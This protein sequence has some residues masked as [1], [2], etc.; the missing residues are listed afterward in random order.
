[1]K[2][3]VFSLM[4]LLFSFSVHAAPAIN[5]IPNQASY[6]VGDIVLLAVTLSE[7]P[8][9]HGGG[10]NIR[11]NPK[12]LQS[13][14]VVVDKVWS[15]ASKP[16]VINNAGGSITD[17]LFSSFNPVGGSQGVAVIQLAVVG[18]GDSGFFVTVS[19]KN[20]FVDTNSQ[21]VSFSVNN[22]FALNTQVAE[23]PVEETPEQVTDTPTEADEDVV[24]VAEQTTVPSTS[25]DVS[26]PVSSSNAAL[27]I[28]PNDTGST[29]NAVS[30][31]EIAAN[32]QN[33]RQFYL[34]S[35]SDRGIPVNVTDDDKIDTQSNTVVATD[36]SARPNGTTA[37]SD[38]K[39]FGEISVDGSRL[40][41]ATTASGDGQSD[42]TVTELQQSDDAGSMEA[43]G[44]MDSLILRL[45][46]GVVFL[47][48]VVFTIVF[49][50]RRS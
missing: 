36:T 31:E 43:E 42:Q 6:Q 32:S 16:G 23:Q 10:L 13:Q 47:L 44:S 12:V 46:V 3:F 45:I 24:P 26:S 38:Q 22:L 8:Q 30:E 21:I 34:P 11:F 50:K 40:V 49:Y 48:V 5:V 18:I 29:N 20:P 7:S 37:Q 41:S 17:I 33:N 4:V 1:M 9:I 14:S 39:T 15:F 27:V 28:L 35:G 25:A 19:E 2:R